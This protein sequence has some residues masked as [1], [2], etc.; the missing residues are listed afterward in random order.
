MA[1]GPLQKCLTV[2]LGAMLA[3]GAMMC[4]RLPARRLATSAQ[5]LHA[6]RGRGAWPASAAPSPQA[7]VLPSQLHCRQHLTRAGKP[8]PEPPAEQTAVRALLGSGKRTAEVL[9][10][11]RTLLDGLSDKQVRDANKACYIKEWLRKQDRR[12][13][14]KEVEALYDY[15]EERIANLYSQGVARKR[16]VHKEDI[17]DIEQSCRLKWGPGM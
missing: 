11:L 14:A 12:A 2:L 8:R 5:A 6:A 17:N 3:A 13:E 10:E 15:I 4:S 9:P 7:V 16:V 1:Q